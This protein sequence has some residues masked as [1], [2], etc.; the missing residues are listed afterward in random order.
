MLIVHVWLV[1]DIKF[2]VLVFDVVGPQ[3]IAIK[4]N[5]LFALPVRLYSSGN[6]F[7]SDNA[8][9]A[10]SCMKTSLFMLHF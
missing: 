10:V 5:A 9:D 7:D 4:Q 3:I 8:K 6:I 2:S 1:S